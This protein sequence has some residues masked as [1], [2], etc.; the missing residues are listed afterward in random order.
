MEKTVEEFGKLKE[1]VQAEKDM[2]EESEQTI[3]NTMKEV[4]SRIKSEIE[5]EKE[6]R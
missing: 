5:N 6:T 1:I 2:R 4:V 3:F